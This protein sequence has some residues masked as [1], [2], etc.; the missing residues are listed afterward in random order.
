MNAHSLVELGVIISNFISSRSRGVK[1][2]RQ[3]ETERN[4]D[5][6][7]PP[8]KAVADSYQLSSCPFSSH[9]LTHTHTPTHTHKLECENGPLIISAE[10]K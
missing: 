10:A 4:G 8:Q 9:T 1:S 7:P 3:K 2:Y 6:P 5:P